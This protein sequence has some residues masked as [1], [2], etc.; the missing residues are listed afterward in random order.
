[1]E[2]LEKHAFMDGFYLTIFLHRGNPL[3]VYK[4]KTYFSRDFI[5][6]PGVSYD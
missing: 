5:P 1:M 4:I 6:S 2:M 3:H